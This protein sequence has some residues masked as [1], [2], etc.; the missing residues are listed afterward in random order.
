[1]LDFSNYSIKSKYDYNLNKLVI[2]K[3]KD[4]T[5][6]VAIKDV[7]GLKPKMHSYV[8]EDSSELK[9]T[10]RNELKCCSNN[11]TLNKWNSK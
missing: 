5:T 10:N 9:R 1:M 3:M 8:V 11:K 2:G 6:G 7:V 4:E